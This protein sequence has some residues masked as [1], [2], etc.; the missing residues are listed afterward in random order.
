MKRA[1]VTG[2]SGFI[3]SHLCTA[4]IEEGLEVTCLDNLSTGKI[5]NLKPLMDRETFR[6]VKGTICD[7]KLLSQLVREVDIVFHLAA[8]VSVPESVTH[9]IACHEQNVTAF[10]KLLQFSGLRMIPVVYAS[11][12]AIYGEGKE[13][14][15][16]E[17]DFPNPLSPYG[18]SKY[19]DEIYARLATRVW[20]IPTVG[21]RFFNVFGPGQSFKGAYA[22]VI[23]AFVTAFL[24]GEIPVIFGDG[25]QVRDFIFVKDAVRA[26]VLAGEK[27]RDIS[28][29]VINAGSGRKTRILD[30]YYAIAQLCHAETQPL[31]KPARPGDIKTSVADTTFMREKLG[32]ENL[33]PFDSAL[34]MTVDSFR[35]NL[36]NLLRERADG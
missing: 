30:L 18:A 32:L 27:A 26:L 28:G 17:T 36:F 3:G 14:P 16:K 7:D 23:P 29:E 34:K 12:S 19:V 20:K 13:S 11:S 2:G 8:M 25:E 6:F 5:E 35:A 31:F 4:L 33:T 22:A 1:L 15:I 9:P 21:L 10:A 24:Q